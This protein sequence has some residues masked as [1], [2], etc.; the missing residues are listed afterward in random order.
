MGKK[1]R[2]FEDYR[3]TALL[4]SMASKFNA[5]ANSAKLPR[6]KLN[7]P[8]LPPVSKLGVQICRRHAGLLPQGVRAVR[9]NRRGPAGASGRGGRNALVTVYGEEGVRR[10]GGAGR[11]VVDRAALRLRHRREVCGGA[12]GSSLRPTSRLATVLVACWRL[13]AVRAGRAL[14]LPSG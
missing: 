5:Q 14:H 1:K 4:N 2:C 13:G 7:E 6:S 10:N 8:N 12:R 11:L 9:G 3:S